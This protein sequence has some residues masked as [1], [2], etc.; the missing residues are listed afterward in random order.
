MIS[1]R[2][3]SDSAVGREPN[4]RSRPP[5]LLAVGRLTILAALAVVLLMPARA[6]AQELN[7]YEVKAAFLYNF[8][9]FVEWPSNAGAD[10]NSPMI[11]GILG[12]DPFGGEIDRAIEGKSVNGHRLTIKRF[13]TIDSYQY[14]HILFVS[15]SEKS[16]LAR[17]LAAVASNSVLTVSE[18]DRF[19]YIGGIINFITIENRIRFEINQAAAARA[20]LKISSKLLSLGR[21]VRT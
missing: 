4:L 15:S 20:G 3:K 14:C 11:I 2:N 12:R 17:I 9:K 5:R 10:P 13:S 21:V 1:T 19:A 16:N 18:T 6:Y 8:A 7:E